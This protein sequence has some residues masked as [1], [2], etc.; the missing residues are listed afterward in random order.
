LGKNQVKRAFCLTIFAQLDGSNKVLLFGLLG[1]SYQNCPDF[2]L[3][4]A[5]Q[6]EQLRENNNKVWTGCLVCPN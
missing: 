1:K 2:K 6:E 3:L 4:A 5:S